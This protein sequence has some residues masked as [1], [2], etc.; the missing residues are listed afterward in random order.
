MAPSLVGVDVPAGEAG[1]GG[2][3]LPLRKT[4]ITRKDSHVRDAHR[5]LHGKTVPVGDG[6]DGAPAFQWHQHPQH[7]SDLDQ[8]Q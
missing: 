2:N 3:A 7:D 6:F 1:A 8:P 4:W 5:L